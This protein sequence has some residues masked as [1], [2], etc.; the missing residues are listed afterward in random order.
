MH[1]TP[2]S[3]RACVATTSPAQLEAWQCDLHRR[4]IH[5]DHS[6]KCALVSST[7]QAHRI[8][9]L[10]KARCACCRCVDAGGLSVPERPAGNRVRRALSLGEAGVLCPNQNMHELEVPGEQATATFNSCMCCVKPHCDRP[11]RRVLELAPLLAMAQYTMATTTVT[12]AGGP[13]CRRRCLW[14]RRR[15]CGSTP[16]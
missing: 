10:C 5:T 15:P 3:R 8:P 6:F 11:G 13:A 9:Q 14:Q 1:C 16:G 12:G 2:C 7:G 4:I